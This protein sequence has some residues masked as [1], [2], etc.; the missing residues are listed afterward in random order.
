MGGKQSSN[1]R[2]SD[3]VINL[4]TEIFRQIDVDGS[5][6]I[7]MEETARWWENNFA[8]INTRAMFDAVD[9]D[10]NGQIDFDEWIH[11][12][13]LVKQNGH[14]D[15]EIEEELTNI[16]DKGSW[17]QFSNVHQAKAKARD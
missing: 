16:R 2:L 10:K 4:A 1:V 6:T 9:T 17:V 3:S 5:L 15:E 7:D 12:W 13:T 14:T 11:F 8:R